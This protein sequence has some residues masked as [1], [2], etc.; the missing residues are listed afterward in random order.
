MPKK[1]FR[2]QAVLL[3]IGFAAVVLATSPTAGAADNRYVAPVGACAHADG[4]DIA[5][6]QARIAMVCLVNF[7]RRARGLK[8]L[9]PSPV[10][11]R[12]AANKLA[13]E[14]RCDSFSHTPC[15]DPVTRAF[16]QAGYTGTGRTVTIG[17]NLA[18][19]YRRSST[20]RHILEAWLS[21]P[22]HRR[23][24]FTPSFRELGLGVAQPLLFCGERDSILWAAAF[25]TGS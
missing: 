16:D 4:L 3:V 12:A 20:P 24:L 13:A 10:L 21:S 22:A 17:E 6:S 23:V 15:G 11:D 18:W 1:L 7:A 25:G 5:P 19:G 8:L 2:A 9:S 14:I